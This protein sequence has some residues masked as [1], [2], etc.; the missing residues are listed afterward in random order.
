L[1]RHPKQTHVPAYGPSRIANYAQTTCITAA[2]FTFKT[3]LSDIL[4]H[5]MDSP[6]ICLTQLG[7]TQRPAAGIAPTRLLLVDAGGWLMA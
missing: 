7:G 3:E 4:F 1:L 2:F 5:L 6:S